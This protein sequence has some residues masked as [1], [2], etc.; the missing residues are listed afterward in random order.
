MFFSFKKGNG[1]VTVTHYKPKPK[2]EWL[3]L[4]LKK[5]RG[6]NR[7][8]SCYHTNVKYYDLPINQFF[9][10]NKQTCDNRNCYL[11]SCTPLNDAYFDWHDDT[12]IEFF[13][14]V[15]AQHQ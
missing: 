15:A 11:S 7:P 1:F 9:N 6:T 2:E 4:Q 3:V 10:H 12:L 5:L 8:T 13:A 14:P